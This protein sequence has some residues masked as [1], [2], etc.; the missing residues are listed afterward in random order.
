[1]NSSPLILWGLDPAAR[2]LAAAFAARLEADKDRYGALHHFAP[3]SDPA[4]TFRRFLADL[5]GAFQKE[6]GRNARPE[7]T[8]LLLGCTWD[9]DPAGSF[10]LLTK[11]AHIMRDLLPGSQSIRLSLLLPPILATEDERVLSF[12]Y[13]VELER[14]VR[15]V[16]FLNI[17]FINELGPG[18]TWAPADGQEASLDDATYAALR[19]QLTDRQMG[20]IIRGRGHAVLDSMS[21]LEGRSCYLSAATTYRLV[22][23]MDVA[24][25]HIE[26]D[27]SVQLFHGLLAGSPDSLCQRTAEETALELSN[28]F[29]QRALAYPIDRALFGFQNGAP[30]SGLE[31]LA[32]QGLE[33][34][35]IEHAKALESQEGLVRGALLE[36]MEHGTTALAEAE[37]LFLGLRGLLPA[38]EKSVCWDPLGAAA[39]D[40]YVSYY[41]AVSSGQSPSPRLPHE[42]RT[43]WFE[44][45]QPSL[46]S[47]GREGLASAFSSTFGALFSFVEDGAASPLPSG[48]VLVM[49]LLNAQNK[50]LDAPPQES[51]SPENPAGAEEPPGRFRRAVRR[52][53]GS[54]SPATPA[55]PERP[56][57]SGPDSRTFFLDVFQS[58][59]PLYATR[60]NLCESF[61]REVTAASEELSSFIEGGR[62]T[63]ERRLAA[64]PAPASGDTAA[65]TNVLTP[66]RLGAVRAR[67]T[68]SK[69]LSDHLREAL[70]PET[71]RSRFMRG[72]S[73]LAEDLVHYAAEVLKSALDLTLLEL[74]EADSQANAHQFLAAKIDAIREPVPFAPGFLPGVEAAGRMQ[75][76]FTIRTI[77]A[78]HEKLTEDPAYS[79]P[80]IGSQVECFDADCSDAQARHRVEL[81]CFVFGFPAF[82][83]H[84]MKE[85]RGIVPAQTPELPPEEDLWPMT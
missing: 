33:S 17:V 70:Q 57:D 28:R 39:E 25:K 8:L 24:I 37:L 12:R 32:L 31:A 26:A 65:E 44:R 53:L 72:P 9:S 62:A 34:A 48:R 18:T 51:A 60:A 84:A 23:P 67:Q 74:L 6:G 45:S 29:S 47:P 75:R 19:M 50:L 56:V 46:V 63:L 54:G 30:S 83:L 68:G 82:L 13:L 1:M 2:S 78:I 43:G 40:L 3:D 81:G 61:R 16:P 11:L 38:I 49:L 52:L 35:R 58:V 66:E 85:A 59:V 42:S 15:S 20:R 4:T 79:A 55:K 14:Q 73:S 69:P 27:F 22:S 80:F 5:I 10:D 64:N 21:R 36:T 71:L 77:P 41:G 7:V 76:I